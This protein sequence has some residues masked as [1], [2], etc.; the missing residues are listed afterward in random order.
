MKVV[1]ANK[2]NRLWRNGVLAKMIAKTKVLNTAEEIEA[3]TSA[4]NVAGALVAKELYNN[5]MQQPEW[6]KD[7][8]GK[9]TGYKTP[10]GADTV[11]PFSAKLTSYGGSYTGNQTIPIS[12]DLLDKNFILIVT[13]VYCSG[14]ADNHTVKRN[15]SFTIHPQIS[16]SGNTLSISGCAGSAMD[17]AFT[18]AVSVTYSIYYY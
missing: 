12:D 16:K 11:F 18:I 15:K 10:G 17:I 3:N 6:I 4:E 2:I 8:T 14:V 13:G 1:T 7:S 9:I 5:L